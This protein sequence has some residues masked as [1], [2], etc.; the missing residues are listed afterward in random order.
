MQNLVNN[1]LVVS[2]KSEVFILKMT[3]GQGQE[4]TLKLNTHKISFTLLVG[5]ICQSFRSHGC[6]SF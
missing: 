2:E 6:N 5:S 3:F 4:M 1:G